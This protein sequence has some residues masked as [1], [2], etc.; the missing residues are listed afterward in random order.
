MYGK[1]RKVEL[2]QSC[3]LWTKRFILFLACSSSWV[4][5]D[6]ACW[7]RERNPTEA[8]SD[9]HV[10]SSHRLTGASRAGA[11][12]SH[13]QQMQFSSFLF[14]QFCFPFSFPSLFSFFALRLERT[15]C[16]QK[17]K[18]GTWC[19]KCCLGWFLY[20]SM[21][22]S[23]HH[24]FS[25]V[26]SVVVLIWDLLHEPQLKPQRHPIT[27]VGSGASYLAEMF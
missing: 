27:Y 9:V 19:F 20:T 15:R 24:T 18:L 10:C 14:V 8:Q 23:F 7:K 16:S 26:S 2:W 5:V 6:S 12:C 1:V 25:S 21:V 4:G 3:S 22:R 13:P 17:M 11:A